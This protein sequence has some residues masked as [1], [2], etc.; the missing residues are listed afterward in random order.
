MLNAIR[1]LLP[2]NTNEVFPIIFALLWGAWTVAPFSAFGASPTFKHMTDVL[3]EDTWG[4]LVIVAGVVGL[5]G[6]ALDWSWL[7]ALASIT[8]FF[9]WIL[10]AIIAYRTSPTTL[11][12][13]VYIWMATASG[14]AFMVIMLG[15][16]RQHD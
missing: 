5:I 9:V 8:R 10:I 12:A 6:L 4:N 14:W 7:R 3:P 15:W 1:R 2:S 16:R 13:P 11:V